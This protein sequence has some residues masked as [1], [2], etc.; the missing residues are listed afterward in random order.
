MWSKIFYIVIPINFWEKKKRFI[1]KKIFY[2]DDQ[3]VHLIFVNLLLVDEKEKDGQDNGYH[4]L[5]LEEQQLE[6]EPFCPCRHFCYQINNEDVNFHLRH[7][8]DK[9]V[10]Y[11]YATYRFVTNQVAIMVQQN[12]P[13]EEEEIDV[14]V[15]HFPLEEKE[16]DNLYFVMH[17]IFQDKK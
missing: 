14:I 15:K 1:K 5:Y 16:M 13:N 9:D 12:E 4:S 8:D 11:Y 6:D 10:Y 17:D 7:R 3:I 2:L